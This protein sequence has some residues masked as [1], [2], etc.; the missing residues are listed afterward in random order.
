[1]AKDGPRDRAVGARSKEAL[2]QFRRESAKQLPL[3]D[4]PFGLATQEIVTEI[5]EVF[6]E[7]IGAV[8]ESLNDVERLGKREEMSQAKHELLP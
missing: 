8:S 7:V 3:A 1:M 4:R 6:S 2:V 5:A